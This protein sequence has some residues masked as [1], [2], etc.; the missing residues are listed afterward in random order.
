MKKFKNDIEKLFFETELESEIWEMIKDFFWR[1]SYFEKIEIDEENN[2]MATGFDGRVAQFCYIH[3]DYEMDKK[4]DFT[5]R[6]IAMIT[7]ALSELKAKEFDSKWDIRTIT[8]ITTY[9]LSDY[10]NIN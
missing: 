6:L 4:N 7:K 5:D 9:K 1:P 10:N 3:L 8:I 2:T